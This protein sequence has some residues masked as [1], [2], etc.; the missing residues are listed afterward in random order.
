MRSA[1][2][3]PS[4]LWFQNLELL[5]FFLMICGAASAFGTN[6]TG[7]HEAAIYL[8]PVTKMLHTF[9]LSRLSPEHVP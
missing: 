8:C 1:S 4:A 2:V 9:Y 6:R 3:P 7:K 5:Q